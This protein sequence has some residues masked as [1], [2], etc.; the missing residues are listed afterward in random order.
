[1]IRRVH[2]G[3]GQ[4][5][6]ALYSPCGAYRYALT[7]AW[8]DRGPRL[9]YLLLNPST[10]TEAQNDPTISRCQKRANLLGYGSFR[11]VNLFAFR[12][13]DPAD[14]KQSSDP[15]GP[16]NR[17]AL[18]ESTLD[19]RPELVICG[20]GVHGSHLGQSAQVRHLLQDWGIPLWHLGL[21]QSGEP[22]HP[23]YIAYSVAPMP[24]GP[25]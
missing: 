3:N 16:Q 21:T 1:M 15:I 23:L 6:E 17:V 18:R 22:R 7:R 4:T 5:S 10:A 24:W 12:A 2:V 9:L 20:W 19:W 14:L 13:T 8:D 11:V 25:L